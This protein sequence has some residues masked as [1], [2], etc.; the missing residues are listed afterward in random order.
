MSQPY[1]CAVTSVLIGGW[2]IATGYTLLIVASV[3]VL[4]CSAG[5]AIRG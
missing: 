2:A 5:L 1:S 3:L 4:C